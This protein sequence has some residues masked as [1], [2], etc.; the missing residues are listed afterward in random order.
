M[1]V[2]HYGI[3]YQGTERASD[4]DLYAPAD[5]IFEFADQPARKPGSRLSRDIHK[6]IDIT[7]ASFIPTRYRSEDGNIASAVPAGDRQDL[8]PFLLATAM[9]SA[10]RQDQAG[11][12]DAGRR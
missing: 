7:V 2:S 11:D 8:R 3:T 12:V 10:A 1:C 5:Q 4:N 9:A 6:K